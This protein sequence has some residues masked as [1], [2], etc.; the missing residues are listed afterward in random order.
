GKEHQSTLNGMV[1][2]TSTSRD[3]NQREQ[4]EKLQMQVMETHKIKL[5]ADYPNTLTHMAN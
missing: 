5:G 3:K 1:N 4:A 2:L